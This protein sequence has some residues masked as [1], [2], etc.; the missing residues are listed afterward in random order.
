MKRPAL[1]ARSVNGVGS[2][3][4][5]KS[6]STGSTRK[7]RRRTY[8]SLYRCRRRSAITSRGQ[9]RAKTFEVLSGDPDAP[10][11]LIL[12]RVGG[13]CREGRKPPFLA[14]PIFVLQAL[15]RISPNVA[16]MEVRGTGLQQTA[17]TLTSLR[18]ITSV[19]WVL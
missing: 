2:A 5:G 10:K 7:L 6:G 16:G 12:R 3:S 4:P 19:R 8:A 18:L 14:L 15:I 13:Q 9:K 1:L 17:L 11:P